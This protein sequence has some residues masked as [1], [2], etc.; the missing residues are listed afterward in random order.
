MNRTPTSRWAELST[1]GRNVGIYLVGIALAVVGAL[2]LAGAIELALATSAG[3]FVA[4]LA[5]VVF[6]HERLGGPL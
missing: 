4:G 3:A 2:G 1:I 5:A 6:V